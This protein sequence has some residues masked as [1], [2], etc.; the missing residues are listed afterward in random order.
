MPTGVPG[1]DLVLGGG[2][3]GGQLVVVAGSP[4]AGKTIVE[5]Y[6]CFSR[7]TSQHPA[8]YFTTLSEPITKLVRHLVPFSFFDADALERRVEFLNLGGLL[9]NE[10]AGLD[11]V[12]DEITRRV[13]DGQPSVVVVD[14]SKALHGWARDD[15]YRGRVYELASKVAHSEAALVFVGE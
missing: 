5:Q 9:K 13:F 12:F 3:G 4:G 1:L 6:F 7:G 15:R 10:G 14:S 8:M 11:A 2:L